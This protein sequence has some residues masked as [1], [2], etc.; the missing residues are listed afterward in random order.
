MAA[1]LLPHSFVLADLFDVQAHSLEIPDF[2]LE[3]DAE[4]ITVICDAC[5]GDGCRLAPDGREYACCECEGTGT[6]ERLE[7]IHT[8]YA[9][10]DNLSGVGHECSTCEDTGWV[11]AGPNAWS[12]LGLTFESYAPCPKGCAYHLSLLKA[13]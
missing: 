4:V 7:V 3:A 10:G 5:L 9:Q 12:R 8:V 11:P 1:S 6:L 2:I 13:A